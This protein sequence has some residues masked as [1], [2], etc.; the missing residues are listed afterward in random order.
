M[1][2]R[3]FIEHICNYCKNKEN[4]NNNKFKIRYKINYVRYKCNEYSRKIKESVIQYRYVDI[5]R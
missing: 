1:N 3:L 2:K 5:K 4:C